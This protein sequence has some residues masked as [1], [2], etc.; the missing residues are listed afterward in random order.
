M[1]GQI[2]KAN[3]SVLSKLRLSKQHDLSIPVQSNISLDRFAMMG[4]Q[5]PDIASEIY[6]ALWSELTAPSQSG[7]GLNRP[8]VIFTI[9]SIAHVMRDSAYMN[10]DVEPIHAHDLAIVNH[11]FKLLSGK[12][13]LSNGG[14]V[15]ATDS[16]SNRPGVPGFDHAVARNAALAQKKDTPQ[17][18]PWVKVDQ[19]TIDILNGVDVWQ[20]KGL[21]RE[22][23]RSIMEYYAK[24]GMLRQTVNDNLVGE[25]WTL[26]GGGI[27]GELEKGTVKTRI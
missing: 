18:D 22:E 14:I 1:L 21:S 15:L 26:S 16:G 23:A 12:E 4:A 10:P 8:P 7:E 13:P 20:I 9:D 3:H 27:I 2:A 17:W 19:R 6:N 25:K 11:F 5:D 24:S